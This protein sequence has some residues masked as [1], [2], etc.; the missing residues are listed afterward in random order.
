V[1][2]AQ[3]TKGM[4]VIYASWGDHRIFHGIYI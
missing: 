1:R 4:M 3:R 2:P